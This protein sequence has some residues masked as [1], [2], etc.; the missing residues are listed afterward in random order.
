MGGFPG[1]LGRK[2]RCFGN[3]CDDVCATF[4]SLSC[5]VGDFAAV[6]A[7][8]WHDAHDSGGEVLW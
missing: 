3:D 4:V 5:G 8:V 2:F 7:V 1:L 6:A